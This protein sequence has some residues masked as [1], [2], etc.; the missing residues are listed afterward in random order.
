MQIFLFT[1]FLST[2]IWLL[3]N[4]LAFK[5]PSYFPNQ[6]KTPKIVG[7]KVK[8]AQEVL[9]KH[10]LKLKIKS[11]QPSQNMEKEI[12]ISQLPLP[13]E[14][15]KKNGTVYVIVSS[16]KATSSLTRQLQNIPPTI[17]FKNTTPATLEVKTENKNSCF[18]F[19]ICIDPGHQ[20]K[21]DLTLEPIGPGSSKTKPKVAGG[22]RGIN[23]HTPESQIVLKIALKLKLLLEEKGI[24]V[25]MT[26]SKENVNIS[27]VQ[28]AQV[29]NKSGADLFVRIHL[30]SS[31]N[32][33][34]KG[35]TTF[36]PAK[37]QWTRKIYSQ[38]KKAAQTIHSYVIKETGA[39]D[40]G[41]KERADM[42][43]FNWS[44]VPVVLVE[45]GFLSNPDEDRKLN[46][47]SYQTKIAIGLAKGILVFL[48][49]K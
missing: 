38:S 6:I 18:G 17:N 28:R 8:K 45:C 29:A 2:L 1:F 40:R 11:H 3:T 7:L 16:G 27:N 42:T 13:G 12:I 32:S 24:K 47:A 37:N 46:N 4:Y 48:K 19:V 14:D 26:R 43:G 10:H 36:Y 9:K 23:T 30:D 15:I 25:V 34:L 35:I 31:S 41:L 33:H 20:A 39:I 22:G 49:G 44:K 21:P 5:T